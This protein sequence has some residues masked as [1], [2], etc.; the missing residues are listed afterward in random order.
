MNSP[1]QELPIK[2]HP[3]QE[4]SKDMAGHEELED[5][6]SQEDCTETRRPI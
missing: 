6:S 1:E 5:E 3:I 2:V 4:R